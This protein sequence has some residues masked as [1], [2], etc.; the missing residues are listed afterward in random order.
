MTEWKNPANYKGCDHYQTVVKRKT[1]NANRT[2]NN[3]T[4]SRPQP[5][6]STAPYQQPSYA[7]VAS[8][9]TASGPQPQRS[10]APYQQPSYAD[11]ARM[12][13]SHA[14]DITGM[15]AKFITEFKGLV[16]QL[17]Q[18]NSMVLNMLTTLLTKLH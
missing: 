6:C 14:D 16:N 11:I 15:L 7:E 13:T 9:L 4:A 8:N 12:N 10:T 18:Q 2:P 1:S 17:L 3:H 5:Q